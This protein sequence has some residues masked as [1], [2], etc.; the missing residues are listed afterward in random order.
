MLEILKKFERVIVHALI[1]MMIIVVFTA[2]VD[3]AWIIIKDAT[4]APSTVLRTT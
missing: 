3:L 2:T 1:V 4:T